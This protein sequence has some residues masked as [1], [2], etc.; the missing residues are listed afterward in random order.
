MRYFAIYDIA[1][2][3]RLRKVAKTMEDYGER[4]QKSKFEM[5]LSDPQLAELQ[6]RLDEIIDHEN[7]GIKY[8]PLCQ[9]C[10]TK[11]EII[12]QGCYCDPDFEYEIV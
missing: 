9:K 7:D 4:V 11:L 1:D 5:T 8:F 12:G 6:A 2:P 3:K 10:R